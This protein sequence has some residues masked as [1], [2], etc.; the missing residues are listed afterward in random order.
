MVNMMEY[1]WLRKYWLAAFCASTCF[2]EMFLMLINREHYTIDVIVGIVFAQYISIHGRNW[3]K[4]KYD[5]IQ[6]LKRLKMNNRK[7][8]KRINVDWDIGD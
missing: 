5:K 4:F 2:I 6:F 3:I 8:L 7:E 1:I